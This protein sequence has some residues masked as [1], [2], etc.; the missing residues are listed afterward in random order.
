MLTQAASRPSTTSLAIFSPSCS[1]ATVTR[2]TTNSLINTPRRKPRYKHRAATSASRRRGAALSR[3]RQ[4]LSQVPCRQ[5]ILEGLAPVYEQHRHLVAKARLEL[6]ASPH[7]DLGERVGNPG[8]HLGEDLLHLIAKRAPGPRVE[9]QLAHVT[10]T[11]PREPSS[12]W[13]CP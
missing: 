4:S 5:T 13:P 8:Q 11:P 2:T 1:D 3:T 10:P 7:V 9:R 12:G 6:G